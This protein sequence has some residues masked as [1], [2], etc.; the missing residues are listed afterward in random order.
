M[1]NNGINMH[2]QSWQITALVDAFVP[3]TETIATPNYD[4]FR[5]LLTRFEGNYVRIA[6]EAG[7]EGN[8]HEKPKE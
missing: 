2:K 8:F 7:P 4:S 6:Y 1:V 5:K 3:F